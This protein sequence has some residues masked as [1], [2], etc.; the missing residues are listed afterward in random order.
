MYFFGEKVNMR[1]SYYWYSFY[2]YWI[3]VG[4][5]V[6]F[7]DVKNNHERVGKQGENAKKISILKNSVR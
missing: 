1:C 4:C 7:L 2:T 5:D 3:L 6:A